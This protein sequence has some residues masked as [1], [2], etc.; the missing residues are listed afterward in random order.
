[1]TKGGFDLIEHILDIGNHSWSKIISVGANKIPFGR[2]NFI[3]QSSGIFPK[4]ASKSKKNYYE[5]IYPIDIALYNGL[6]G[7]QQQ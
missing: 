5:K 7:L 4:L 6:D 3:D 2:C 1:M